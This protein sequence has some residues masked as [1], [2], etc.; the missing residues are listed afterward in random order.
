M[1]GTKDY[2]AKNN[3]FTVNIAL[4]KNGKPFI[5]VVFAPAINDLYV[6]VVGDK[7]WKLKNKKRIILKKQKKSDELFLVT[8]RFHDAPGVSTFMKNN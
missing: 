6:G 2:L 5:G 8:S 3:E 1:D 4:M 7:A